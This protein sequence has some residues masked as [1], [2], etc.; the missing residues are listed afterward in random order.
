MP[1]NTAQSTLVNRKPVL[2]CKDVQIVR[3]ILGRVGITEYRITFHAMARAG[4]LGGLHDYSKAY[5]LV[6]LDW[7]RILRSM[8]QASYLNTD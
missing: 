8:T 5:V 2:D 6:V 3:S 7:D 4:E 1:Q